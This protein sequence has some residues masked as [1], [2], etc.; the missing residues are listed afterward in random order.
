MGGEEEF[1]WDGAE[2]KPLISATAT[3]RGQVYWVDQEEATKFA[4]REE[5]LKVREGSERSEL[6]SAALYDKLTLLTHHSLLIRS[7]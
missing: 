5:A 2:T 7:S 4:I 1:D 3:E 6:P